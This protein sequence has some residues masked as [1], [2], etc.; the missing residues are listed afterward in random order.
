VSGSSCGRGGKRKRGK[1]QKGKVKIHHKGLNT[2]GR[3]VALRWSSETRFGIVAS[4]D[5]RDFSTTDFP[6]TTMALIR[7]PTGR[8]GLAPATGIVDQMKE[9]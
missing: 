1:V 3:T 4:I 6:Q 7:S 2:S 8:R 5:G 9:M